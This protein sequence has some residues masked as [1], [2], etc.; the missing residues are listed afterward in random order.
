MSS[1]LP[2]CQFYVGRRVRQTY[3]SGRCT[4]EVRLRHDV[5][6]ECL[7]ASLMVQLAR[8]AAFSEARVSFRIASMGHHQLPRPSPLQDHRDDTLGVWET[9]ERLSIR[10]G[11]RPFILSNVASTVPRKRDRVIKQQAIVWLSHRQWAKSVV[12]GLPGQQDR[13]TQS[14]RTSTANPRVS[15]ILM[16]LGRLVFC[17]HSTA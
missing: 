5:C 15:N 6:P 2:P 9:T 10:S 14:I 7:R 3:D 8:H 11:A 1:I 12:L 17:I 13:C 16:C 4:T